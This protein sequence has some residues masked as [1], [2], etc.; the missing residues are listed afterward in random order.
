MHTHALDSEPRE[1]QAC[2]LFIPLALAVL[3]TALEQVP[4]G[5]C[6]IQELCEMEQN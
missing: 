1:V 3:S 2:V 5:Y 6:H 4:N